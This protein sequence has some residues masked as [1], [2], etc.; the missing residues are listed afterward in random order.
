MPAKER[1]TATETAITRIL[2]DTD[3]GGLGV[4]VIDV[5]RSK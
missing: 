4:G 2:N 3:R 1:I 5:A